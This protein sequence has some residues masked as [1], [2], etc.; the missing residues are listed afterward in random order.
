M[1][2]D[3]FGAAIPPALAVVSGFDTAGLNVLVGATGFALHHGLT[4]VADATV[5]IVASGEKP[6][7]VLAPV[8]TGFFFVVVDAFF[9][10]AIPHSLR[11][12]NRWVSSNLSIRI[13]ILGLDRRFIG[14]TEL[15]ATESGLNNLLDDSFLL[16]IYAGLLLSHFT[17]VRRSRRWD[18]S[19]ELLICCWKC[20]IRT[21]VF[22]VMHP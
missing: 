1:V 19:S 7:P 8:E 17:R 15:V 6:L 21:Y 13:R 16:S 3:A 2:S 12:L 22:L 20:H 11:V 9:L 10:L 5:P 14:S 18:L 4:D